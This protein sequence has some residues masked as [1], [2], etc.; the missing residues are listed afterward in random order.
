MPQAARMP[1]WGDI[2]RSGEESAAALST[3]IRKP[4]TRS[5]GRSRSRTAPKSRDG[6]G[7]N[8]SNNSNNNS[9][10]SLGLT[11]PTAKGTA[12]TTTETTM[13]EWS[14]GICY[15]AGGDEHNADGGRIYGGNT[16]YHYS[17]CGGPSTDESWEPQTVATEL[18]RVQKHIQVQVKRTLKR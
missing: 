11:T 5:R 13:G 14:R 8:S 7:G 6:A 3:I 4:S 12:T 17:I 18:A 2:L 10:S 1:V 9:N 15:A 16:Q